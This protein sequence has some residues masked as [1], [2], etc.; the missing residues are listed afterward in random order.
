MKKVLA[1]LLAITTVLACFAAC[2]KAGEA[3][4]VDEPEILKPPS[5]PEQDIEPEEIR[6]YDNKIQEAVVAV[7]EAYYA[8]GVYIQYEDKKFISSGS[9]LRADRHK[10]SPED[11]TSQFTTYSNCAVFTYDVYKEALGI[12]IVAWTCSGLQKAVDMHALTSTTPPKTDEEKAALKQRILDTLQ[13]GDII[14][15][16]KGGS[17][18]HA[19]LYIGYDEILHCTS[20]FGEG[21]SYNMEKNTEVSEPNG[22]ILRMSIEDLW[23]KQELLESEQF[24]I[25]R[26]TLRHTEAKPT[27]NALNRVKNL[28]NIYVEKLCDH[29][30]GMTAAPD[31]EITF[32]FL[33]KNNNK[34]AKT[35]EIVEPV[36]SNTTYVSGADSVAGDTLKWSVD[37]EGNSEKQISYTVKV[38]A[39]AKIGAEIYSMSKV[40]G[41]EVECRPTFVGKNLSAAEQKKIYDEAVKI[42]G[43]SVTGIALAKQIYASA[44]LSCDIGT[45]SEIIENIYQ[46]SKMAKNHFQLNK[47][48]KYVN[49]VAPTMYGGFFVTTDILRFG[50]ARTKG[51]LPN[52]IMAGDI[53]LCKEGD[54]YNVYLFVGNEIVMSLNAGSVGIL[55]KEKSAAALLSTIG[56]DMFVIL[57]PAMA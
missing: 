56:H 38:N 34:S 37:L 11:A 47:E 10:Y 15:H 13:P 36:P 24:C 16:L 4:K 57:R 40:G 17:W 35:V 45:E 54:V 3:D 39:D 14:A 28:Q 41:V 32:T 7:A 9:I 23:T 50:G 30:A 20:N 18:G 25:V 21:G 12:D 49:M 27:E 2:T 53:I 33:I 51:P 52:Q 1:L 19:M 26:P 44:G 43:D 29:T 22:G 55:D 46:A 31:E 5:D 8:R 6:V 42:S 48:S